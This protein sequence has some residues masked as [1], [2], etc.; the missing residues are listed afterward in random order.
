M[1]KKSKRLPTIAQIHDTL[2][3]N[4]GNVKATCEDLTIDRNYF[5]VLLKRN[6]Q[7]GN[8]LS[9]ARRRFTVKTGRLR[10][11]RPNKPKKGKKS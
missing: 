4:H 11:K 5:Y 7:I 3:R 1:S 9:M 2:S 6:P 10:N 8:T